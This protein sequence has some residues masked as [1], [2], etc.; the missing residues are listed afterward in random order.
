M[1]QNIDVLAPSCMFD[2]GGGRLQPYD[3]NSFVETEETRR[4]MKEMDDDE[5]LV[6]GYEWLGVR[7]GRRPL[8]TFYNPKGNRTEMIGLDGVGATVLLVRG[9]CH[10]EGLTFPTVPYKHLIESEALGKL[11][12]DMGFEVKGMPNYVVRH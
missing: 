12:Q 1:S 7:T 4:I 5:V 2:S 9:D 3:L 10:R 8:G 6:D 11:A